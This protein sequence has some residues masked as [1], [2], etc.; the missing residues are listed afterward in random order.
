MLSAEDVPVKAVE[1]EVV[2][3]ALRAREDNVVAGRER[4][5]VRGDAALTCD[6]AVVRIGENG[7]DVVPGVRDL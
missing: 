1:P 5:G 6:D 7:S 2:E 3:V 4:D